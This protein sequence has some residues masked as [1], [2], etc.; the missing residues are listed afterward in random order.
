MQRTPEKRKYSQ[1]LREEQAKATRKRIL[2]GMLE[3]SRK[4]E[5]TIPELARLTKVSVPTIYRYF[6]TREALLTATLEH[7]EAQARNDS[8]TEAAPDINAYPE[9][10]RTFF[11]ARFRVSEQ[12]GVWE[13]HA[14]TWEL[15]KTVTIPRRRA[16]MRQL[17]EAWNPDL[18]EPHRTWLE[19]ILVVLVSSAVVS[20]FKNYVGADAESGADRLTWILDALKAHAMQTQPTRKSRKNP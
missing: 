8:Q 6:P 17:I 3:G 18:R 12:L 20:A 4:K 9:W 2:E 11:H 10:I 5:I 14:L 1:T 19:D 15:R 7:L 13:N 16:Y